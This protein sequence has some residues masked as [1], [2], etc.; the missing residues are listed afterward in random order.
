MDIS[1]IVVILVLTALSLGAIAWMELHSRKNSSETRDH[2]TKSPQLKEKKIAA[3]YSPVLTLRLSGP[4][5]T[6]T[7]TQEKEL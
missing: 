2:N 6:K 3:P 4:S 1:A 5:S 7:R